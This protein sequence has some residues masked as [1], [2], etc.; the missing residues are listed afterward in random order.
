MADLTRDTT[1]LGRRLRA[2]REGRSWSRRTLAA[3][4]G[5]SEASIAR[6]ELYGHTP[7]LDSISRWAT[8]LDVA[9]TDLLEP[10]A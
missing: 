5:T 9:L 10:A 4:S 3:R 6:T 8:A 7:K 1:D 2:L